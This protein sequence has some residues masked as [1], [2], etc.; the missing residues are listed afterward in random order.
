M[1]A[2]YWLIAYIW[3]YVYVA[4]S[5]GTKSFK[6]LGPLRVLIRPCAQV[7]GTISFVFHFD[8]AQ[9][10]RSFIEKFTAVFHLVSTFLRFFSF[11]TVVNLKRSSIIVHIFAVNLKCSSFNLPKA[12][13]TNQKIAML[14]FVRLATIGCLLA[15]SVTLI[16]HNN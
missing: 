8:P 16:I 6:C 3:N 5:W 7:T 13:L 9:N 4:Q 1:H 15:K 12:K 11:Q 14:K 10:S 2:Y